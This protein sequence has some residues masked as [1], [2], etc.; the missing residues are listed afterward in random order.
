[1]SFETEPVQVDIPVATY[2][3]PTQTIITQ[4][5][6]G[7]LSQSGI[8]ATGTYNRPT[9]CV[10][11]EIECQA[12]GGTSPTLS[13]ASK[14]LDNVSMSSGASAGNYIKFGISSVQFDIV[15]GESMDY[16]TGRQDTTST[17]SSPPTQENNNAH[18]TLGNPAQLTVRKGSNSSVSASIRRNDILA[19]SPD[20]NNS[21]FTAVFEA[22]VDFLRNQI[23]AGGNGS[24]T[25]RL[26]AV[27]GTGILHGGKG[28]N[29]VL[30]FS[31]E[32]VNSV[33]VQPTG[34]YGTAPLIGT[35]YGWGA[36]GRLWTGAS[37]FARRGGAGGD[38]VIII[39]EFYQ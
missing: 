25:L 20:T 19:G 35:G 28:A 7:S 14:P 31:G 5:Q 9:D 39:R 18:L 13:T 33:T 15:F 21:F 16:F 4:Q 3:A 8:A 37:S 29:S 32:Q 12:A 23:G 38:A 36:G 27:N 22:N 26:D 34:T 30:G 6:A 1:M 10:Y 17:F 2:K 24:W 11:M